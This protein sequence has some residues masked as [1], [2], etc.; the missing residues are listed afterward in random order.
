MEEILRKLVSHNIKGDV[1]FRKGLS[2][3]VTFE[4]NKLKSIETSESS[5]IG[6][7]V[8]VDGK[9]GYSS[10][11]GT[12]DVDWLFDKAIA[13]TNVETNLRLPNQLNKSESFSDKGLKSIST[14][15][16]ARIGKEM[17]ER[18]ISKY[19]DVLC[20]LEFSKDTGEVVIKNTEGIDCKREKSI[21]SMIVS[22]NRIKGTD[23][24]EVYEEAVVKEMNKLSNER[25]ISK[26]FNALEWSKEITKPSKTHIPVI[27]TPKAVYVL[28][29]PIISS[30]NGKI[31]IM[32][33]SPLQD[34]VGVKV[35]DER[36]SLVEDPFNKEG[37]SS[38]SFDDEG[39][40][41][42]TFP[43][44]ENGVIGGFYFDLHTASLIGKESNGHG[45]RSGLNQ[46]SPG[47]TN[48]IIL[49][50]DGSIKDI[51]ASL[52]EVLVVDQMM[53]VGQGNIL[54]GEFSINV[55]LGYLYRKGEIVGR[56]KDTM[57]AGN[58]YDALSNI[59]ALSKETEW[60]EGNLNTP[61]ICIPELTVVS[62]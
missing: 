43:L 2:T 38:T 26:L 40:L 12:Y 19:P 55:H 45:F 5:G 3:S 59:L 44:I 29:L 28:L 4:A 46:P 30:L 48:L 52:D 20:N 53:G 27:F 13:T 34:K 49:P 22:V 58:A 21:L 42:K 39:I 61:Y 60:I 54:S 35:F 16:L 50:G 56:V 36:F 1:V 33:A 17:I 11:S 37:L 24:L 41:T 10:Q 31:V 6:L 15:G 57:V 23:M 8:I 18:I 7:R 47:L 14:E 62:K 25:I 32:G 51:I 9:I